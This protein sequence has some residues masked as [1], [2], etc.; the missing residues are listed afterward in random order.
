MTKGILRSSLASLEEEIRLLKEMIAKKGFFPAV[1][2]GKFS[3]LEGLWKH[4]A[5]FS[6]EEIKSSEIKLQGGL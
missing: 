3:S 5:D 2:K 4:K 1:S 6:L